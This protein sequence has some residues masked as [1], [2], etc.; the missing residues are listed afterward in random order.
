MQHVVRLARHGLTVQD[1]GDGANFL[2]KHTP[3]TAGVTDQRDITDRADTQTYGRWIEQGHVAG[4]KPA[5][6]QTLHVET[7][8]RGR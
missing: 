6:L 5:L 8:L 4:E 2:R 3:F 7:N 1:F